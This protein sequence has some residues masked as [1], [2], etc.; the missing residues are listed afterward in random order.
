MSVLINMNTKRKKAKRKGKK[1]VLISM[2]NTKGITIIQLIFA[3][4]AN[5]Y[6]MGLGNYDKEILLL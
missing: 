1:E 4:L 6:M 2:L 5:T 3:W